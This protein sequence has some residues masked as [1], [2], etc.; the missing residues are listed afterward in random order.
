MQNALYDTLSIDVVSAGYV[1]RANHTSMKFSGFTAVYV[2]SRDEDN[3]ELDDPLPDLKQGEPLTLAETEPDQ[4]FT[5]PPPRYTEASLIKAMEELGIGRPSTYAPTISTILEREYVI[6]QGKT[7]IP[8]PLGEVVTTMMKEKFDDIINVSF[9]ARMENDL[10][11]VE[12]GSRNWKS[13]LT[14]FYGVFHEALTQAAEDKTRYRVP[15][16]P[17]DIVCELCGK[18]MVVKMGRFGRFIAC[19][20]YP[21]CK[22]TK[23]ISEPTAGECPLCSATILKKKS[24]NNRDYY[25]CEKY[26]ACGFMTWDVPVGERCPECARTLFKRGGRGATKP[27]CANAE[28]PAFLPEDQRGY[29]R[30]KTEEGEGETKSATSEG[31]SNEK[32][33]ADKGSAVKK[34][35][36]AKKT[37]ATKKT[38][39]AAKKTTTAA[40]K[41]PAAA[42]K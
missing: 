5:Q 39:T 35:T 42:K 15:D 34:T 26:P 37:T 30:K 12:A 38:T 3:E 2:E 11:K 27:F 8:T 7:I 41:K 10:D 36:A 16:E 14:D 21:D 18:Q 6:K 19:P 13:M 17:T 28:C 40:K 31:K 20:G 25:G 4:H 24:R 9:T 32:A 1:F 29:R 22:N 23:P 33:A